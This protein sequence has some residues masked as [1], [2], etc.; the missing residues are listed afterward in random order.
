MF[1]NSKTT[2]FMNL[3]LNFKNK[4]NKQFLYH[5]DKTIGYPLEG[6]SAVLASLGFLGPQ[7]RL[8]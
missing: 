1:V 6:T 8:P 4:Y 2:K 5:N 7:K 3:N